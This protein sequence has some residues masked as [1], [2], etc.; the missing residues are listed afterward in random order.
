MGCFGVVQ[1]PERLSVGG[2]R[3]PRRGRE[4]LHPHRDR[5]ATGGEPPYTWSLVK[6]L[7]KLPS[8]SSSLILYGGRVSTH[9][10]RATYIAVGR[11]GPVNA[12]ALKLALGSMLR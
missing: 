7:G 10:L 5:N 9:V 8:A 11:Y 4:H 3:V 2:Q 1:R 6:G 12:I